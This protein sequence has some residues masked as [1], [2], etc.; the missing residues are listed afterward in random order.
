MSNY[1]LDLALMSKKYWLSF[2]QFFNCLFAF[3]NSPD[4]ASLGL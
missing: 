3:G 4:S 2:R 1:L